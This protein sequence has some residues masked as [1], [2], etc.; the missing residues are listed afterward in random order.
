MKIRHLTYFIMLNFINQRAYFQ[1][2]SYNFNE[3][4][5]LWVIIQFLHCKVATW[6]WKDSENC[7][8]LK[9]KLQFRQICIFF[10]NFAAMKTLIYGVIFTLLA[11]IAAS[12]VGCSKNEDLP[13]APLAEFEKTFNDTI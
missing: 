2:I 6:F 3:V 9:K 1:R 11:T 13:D 12:F 4:L 8:F 5:I 10:A 7:G